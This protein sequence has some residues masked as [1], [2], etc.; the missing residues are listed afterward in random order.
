M[1]K[2]LL[3]ILILVVAALP[4]AFAACS[5]AAQSTRLST[6]YVCSK[7]GYELFTYDAFYKETKIGTMTMKFSPLDKD[8]IS[9]P[10]PTKEGDYVA[11]YTGTLLETSLTVTDGLLGEK[12]PKAGDS[13]VSYVLYGGD[14]APTYSYKKTIVDGVT[15]E[16]QVVYEGKYAY[17]KLYENGK[18]TASAKLK[19]SGA[20]DN[21]MIYALARASVIDDSSYSFSFKT[22]NALTSSLESIAITKSENTEVAVPCFE[23]EKTA[24]IRFAVS[25][26]NKYASSHHLTIA[27]SKQKV[28]DEH[29]TEVMLTKPITSITE[30]DIKYNLI[31]VEI[32]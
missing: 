16:M 28:T 4:V 31:S 5:R 19:V 6:G 14:F 10:D 8:T 11:E 27:S 26:N 30:G 18:E 21:E 17:T 9:L 23:G 13:L 22:P 24:C 7:D 25:T 15:K 32:D 2:V 12:E 3:I 29:G 20:Y 1:K